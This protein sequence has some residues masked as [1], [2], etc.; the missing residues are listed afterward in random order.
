MKKQTTLRWAAF[1]LIL[2]FSSAAGKAQSLKDFFSSESTSALWL[3]IDFT[4]NKLIDEP[5]ANLSD[6]RDRQYNGLN[7]LIIDEGKKYNLKAAFHRTSELDHDVN[8]VNDRNTKVNED[9]MKST[10]TSDFHRLKEEDISNLVRGYDLKG[11]KGIGI[12]MVSEAMGK[13][14]K[15]IALWV[16]II[17]MSTKKVLMT[18]RLEGK[19]SMGF[20][21]RNFWAAGIKSVIEQ[22]EKKK[23]KEWKA[24]AGA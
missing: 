22:I 16:V 12:L 6:I 17:D 7:E 19:V 9:D 18:D 20:G 21:F 3:G 8:Y 14:E 5:T 24:K 23:Y 10:N 2:L 11:K 13:S 15:A 1:S 4:K